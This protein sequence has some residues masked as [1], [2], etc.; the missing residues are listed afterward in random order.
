MKDLLSFHP[1]F[2]LISHLW[3][4]FHDKNNVNLQSCC[5]M[6]ELHYNTCFDDHNIIIIIIVVL[7]FP[8]E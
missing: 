3:L 5:E 7:V 8:V 1:I 2:S 4:N 6:D